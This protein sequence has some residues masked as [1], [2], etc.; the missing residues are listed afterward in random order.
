[1]LMVPSPPG[2]LE[3][4]SLPATTSAAGTTVTASATTHTKGAWTQ[5]IANTGARSLGIMVTLD[6][7]AASNTATSLLVDIGIGASGSEQVLIP[8]LAAGYILPQATGTNLRTYYFPVFIPA[9][10]R[11]AARSQGTIASDTVAVSLQLFQRP[12]GAGF[13]GTRVTAYGVNLATSRGV[14]VTTGGTSAYGTAGTISASTANSIRYMQVGMQGAGRATL[15][16]LRVYADVRLGASTS[17]AGP[18]VGF[19]DTGT[20]S[21]TLNMGNALLQLQTFN[22]PAGQDLR[23]AAMHNSATAAAYDFIVYGVD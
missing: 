15:T 16:D 20:E 19:A 18:L 5:L 9:G 22:L 3:T 8:N 10:S 2:F 12:V 13:V 23:I 1:M 7:T 6:N 21:V 4:V 17:I 11:I 14:D